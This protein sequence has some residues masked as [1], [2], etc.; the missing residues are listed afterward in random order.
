L[1]V[2]VLA[3]IASYLGLRLGGLAGVVLAV[4]GG[5]RFFDRDTGPGF[6]WL[7]LTAIGTTVP[8]LLAARY[9][10]VRTWR[11]GDRWQ[12]LVGVLFFLS[13]AA[14]Q[15]WLYTVASWSLGSVL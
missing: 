3:V 9:V 5:S 14:G 8:W 11:S 15:A 12:A 1:G 6:S 13:F 10:A 4:V 2:L 7:V